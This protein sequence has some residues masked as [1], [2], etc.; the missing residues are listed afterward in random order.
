VYGKATTEARTEKKEVASRGR[1]WQKVKCPISSPNSS[2]HGGFSYKLRITDTMVPI[3]L[4]V[5]NALFIRPQDRLIHLN[6]PRR[7]QCKLSQIIDSYN[8]L[9]LY[10]GKLWCQGT[11]PTVIYRNISIP[12]T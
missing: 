8:C 5:A 4:F 11:F 1:K 7:L 12:P 2:L 3:Q 6:A 9:L 10:K